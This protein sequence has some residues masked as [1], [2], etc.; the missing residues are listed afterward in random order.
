MC[1]RCYGGWQVCRRISI[2]ELNVR[3]EKVEVT[4]ILGCFLSGGYML[5]LSIH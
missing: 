3:A 4:G 1:G 2:S 5:H